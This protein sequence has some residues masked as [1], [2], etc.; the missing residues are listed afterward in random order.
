MKLK[1]LLIVL[2][3]VLAIKVSGQIY[4][5]PNATVAARVADLLSVMSLEEKVGQMT[6]ISIET[7]LEHPEHDHKPTLP[8]TIITDKLREAV[9]KY[10]VGSILNVGTAA[11]TKEKWHEIIKTIQNPS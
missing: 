10:G 6:Q 8:F 1:Q 5:D 3:A 2:F 9:V 7:F 11:H 4:K